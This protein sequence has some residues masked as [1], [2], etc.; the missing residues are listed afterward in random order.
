MALPDPNLVNATVAPPAVC[1]DNSTEGCV[2]SAQCA[3]NSTDGCVPGVIPLSTTVLPV[4][5]NVT[6]E[7]D[8]MMSESTTVTVTNKD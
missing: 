4:G 3:G 7:D 8:V 2:T 1:A 6:K 5:E